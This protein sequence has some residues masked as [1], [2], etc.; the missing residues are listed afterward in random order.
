MNSYPLP[1]PSSRAV[2]ATA[3]L[4]SSAHLQSLPCASPPSYKALKEEP[5]TSTKY[6]GCSL[7]LQGQKI[8]KGERLLPGFSPKKM[9]SGGRRG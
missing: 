8:G 1:T 3:K 9:P 7:E 5:E 6:W 4:L 2:A